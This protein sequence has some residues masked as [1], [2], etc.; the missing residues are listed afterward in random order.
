MSAEGMMIIYFGALRARSFR[1]G[2]NCLGQGPEAV[3][4]G[5]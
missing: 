2:Y 4:G 1:Y 5:Q 3:Q